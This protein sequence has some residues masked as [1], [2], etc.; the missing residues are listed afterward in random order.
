MPIKDFVPSLEKA[1]L[2]SQEVDKVKESAN[3]N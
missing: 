1:K 2:I 3:L